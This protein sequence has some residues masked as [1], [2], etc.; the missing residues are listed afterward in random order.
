M[1]IGIQDWILAKFWPFFPMA[2]RKYLKTTEA[3]WGF[4]PMLPPSYRSFYL[5]KKL[6]VPVFVC[7]LV[8]VLQG[9]S[10]PRA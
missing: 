1:R 7:L 8:P 9:A 10:P 2:A 5:N 4:E 3:C 6:R